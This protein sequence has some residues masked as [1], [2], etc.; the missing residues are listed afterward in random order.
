M[1]ERYSRKTYIPADQ[2]GFCRFAGVCRHAMVL[3]RAN[4][5][6]G[7]EGPGAPGH[8]CL[9]LGHALL[10]LGYRRLYLSFRPRGHSGLVAAGKSRTVRP[11]VP[12]RRLLTDLPYP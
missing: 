2:T 11:L 10:D 4:E 1:E 3:V 7:A 8:Q 12:V 9:Y 5:F 6:Q